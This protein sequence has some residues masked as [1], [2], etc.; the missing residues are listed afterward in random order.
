MPDN[1]PTPREAEMPEG[2]SDP[3]DWATLVNYGAPLAPMYLLYM[4]V[5]VVYMNFATDV[6]LIAPGVVGTVFFVSK[7]WDAV[8]DPMVGYLSDR[9]RSRLGRRKPWLYG[10]VIPIVATTIMLWSPPADLSETQLLVWVSVSVLGFYTA[11]TIYVIPQMALGLELSPSPHERSRVFA[12][13]QVTLTLGMLGAFIIATP[14][15]IDNPAARENA[16]LISAVAVFVFA[17]LIVFCTRQLPTERADDARRGAQNPIAAMRDVIKNPHARLLL[18]V[19]F[20]EIFGIGATSAMTPYLL[21]YVIKAADYVGIV[22][23]FYTVPA[24]ASIPLWVSLGKRYERHKL[25][26]FAM[27]LQAIGYGLIVFQ[28]EGLLWLMILSSVING[29]ATAC[30]Q[31]LGY[32]I[33]GDVIDYDE[34]MT[35]ERKEGSYLAAWSLAAKFGTGFMIAISGWALQYVGFEPNTEQSETV[36]W[37]IKTMTGGAPFVCI[38]IGMVAFSRYS[39]G[40]GEAARIRGVLR[41]RGA[42]AER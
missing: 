9:T 21:K 23:L 20:I 7:L 27:G 19:Y 6:L 29:F 16:T 2:T 35:G 32:A 8:S 33:K 40:S 18:F 5:V 24:F 13:R 42:K 1:S 28:A 30:G 17:I 12:G 4:M 3:I 38:L 11:F 34:Y 10:S 14:M 36:N 41:S 31:T 15:I 26:L 39:L 25:W 37:T 22:F